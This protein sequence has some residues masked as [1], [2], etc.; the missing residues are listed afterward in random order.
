MVLH[1]HIP[2]NLT[3]RSRS[4]AHHDQ[5]RDVQQMRGLCPNGSPLMNDARFPTQKGGGAKNTDFFICT[6]FVYKLWPIFHIL[7]QGQNLHRLLSLLHLPHLLFF[8][9][10]SV[11]EI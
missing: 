1:L 8:P 10:I 9:L 2:L 3:L 5:N 7:N 4:P 11:Y 6:I